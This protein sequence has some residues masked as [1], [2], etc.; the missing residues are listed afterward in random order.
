MLLK[1]SLHE[2]RGICMALSSEG[3]HQMRHKATATQAHSQRGDVI[4][5]DTHTSRKATFPA[6]CEAEH[7]RGLQG[8]A[9]CSLMRLS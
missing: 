1:Q 4:L 6:M 5:Q 7:G 9:A 3:V 8:T 2:Q